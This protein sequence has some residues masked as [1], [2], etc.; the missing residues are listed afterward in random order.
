[1]GKPILVTLLLVSAFTAARS[2]YYYKDIVSNKQVLAEREGLKEQKIRNILVHSFEGNREPSPG[3]FCEKKITK[4]YRRM[5]TYTKSNIT[6]K[7]LQTTYYNDKDQLI[8]S[9][10]SSELSVTSSFYEYDSKGN[11]SNII[12]QSHSNDEDFS[13]NL[14]EEHQYTYNEKGI[15]VK[16]LRIRNKK[17]SSTIIFGL[18]EKG[19][20]I[21][22]NETAKNGKHYY[23]YYNDK[24]R[25]TDIVKFNV[26]KKKL[27]PDFIFEYNSVGQV[28]QMVTVE[29]GINSDYYTWK[30][31]YN[32][33]LRIIEKCFSKEN[34]LLGYFEYE[35]D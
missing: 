18:D 27:L 2:Q 12:S 34:I 5:E 6:G 24:N 19:N 13:T 11:I 10:D 29:E 23:Y 3:F 1:M 33:G 21:D 17:D 31:I 15:P 35:Y 8:Q 25:L 7:A 28:T 16:M 26:V 20:V 32:D 9:T 30:Y 22:E 14:L 4:D